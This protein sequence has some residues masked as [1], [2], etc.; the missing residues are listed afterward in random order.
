MP[1]SETETHSFTESLRKFGQ[2][3]LNIF[4]PING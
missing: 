4:K 3:S 1:A 2:F